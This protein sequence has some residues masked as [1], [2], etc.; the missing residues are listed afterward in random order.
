MHIEHLAVYVQDLERSRAFYERW[1]RATANARY[2]SRNS[3]GFASYF[4][5]FPHGGARIELM[6]HSGAV[7][8]AAVAVAVAAARASGYAHL[9][10]RVD[11]EQLVDSL[12]A[13]ML[14]AG[15][16]MVSAPRRTGD[17][18]YESVIADPDGNLIEI[19]A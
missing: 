7:A 1:F 2:D 10:I 13:T 3:P 14:E 17:G 9:A 18:Y 15:V 12:T 6:Q 4:L 19:V 11:D 5:T 16:T 8:V